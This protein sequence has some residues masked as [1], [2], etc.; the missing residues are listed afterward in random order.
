MFFRQQLLKH[1]NIL[2]TEYD[3]AIQY[4]NEHAIGGHKSQQEHD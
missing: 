1:S 2:A 3:I 4:D